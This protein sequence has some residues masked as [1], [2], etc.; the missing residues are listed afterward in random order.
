MA[1]KEGGRRAGSRPVVDELDIPEGKRRVLKALPVRTRHKDLKWWH[2]KK[3]GL[4]V[5]RMRKNFSRVERALRKVAGGPE[6]LKIPLDRPGSRIWELCDGKHTVLD[7]ARIMNKE[8]QE[9][10]E[11]VLPRVI[12]FMELLLKRNLISLCDQG[13]GPQAPPRAPQRRVRMLRGSS[14][15]DIK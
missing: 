9:D 8:F 1:K 7:I 4:I 2:G 13:P 5:I 6:F 10:M 11:P 14:E 12:K 15:L 3:D